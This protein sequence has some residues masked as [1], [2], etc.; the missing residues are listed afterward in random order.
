[1]EVARGEVEFGLHPAPR[2]VVCGGSDKFAPCDQAERFAHRIGARFVT[3]AARGHWL[4]AGRALERAVAEIQR[5]LVRA[6][7]EDLLLLYSEH[8]GGDDEA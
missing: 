8:G 2:L 1:M 7:G 6:L 4:V 3:L 5:F